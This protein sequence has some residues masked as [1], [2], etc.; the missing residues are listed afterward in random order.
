MSAPYSLATQSQILTERHEPIGS[1]V[2][3]GDNCAGV[4]CARIQRT[5]APEPLVPSGPANLSS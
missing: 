4:G 1:L 2:C 5:A 3:E